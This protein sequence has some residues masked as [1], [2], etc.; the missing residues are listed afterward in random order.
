M[1]SRGLLWF[2]QTDWWPI[3][4]ALNEE[5]TMEKIANRYRNMAIGDH[6]EELIF[7]EDPLEEEGDSAKREVVPRI[8]PPPEPPPWV[9]RD[10]GVCESFLTSFHIFLSFVFLLSSVL[11]GLS[12]WLGF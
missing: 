9:V 4:W 2:V 10:A 7:E 11:L 6:E 3:D 8:R 1:G 5:G 12:F